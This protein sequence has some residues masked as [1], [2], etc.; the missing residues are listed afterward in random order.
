MRSLSSALVVALLAVTHVGSALHY[1]LVQHAVADDGALVHV[2]ETGVDA[3]ETPN[4][5]S[6]DATVTS[7]PSSGCAVAAL[8]RQASQMPAPVPAVST[9][10]TALSPLPTF[11]R[12]VADSGD[13]YRLAPKMGPPA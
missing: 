7:L 9:P 11:C 8:Q 1:A 12:R 10:N 3:A 6:A 4:S 5:V 2:T 13:T